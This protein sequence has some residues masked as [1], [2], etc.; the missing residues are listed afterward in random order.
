MTSSDVKD[1]FIGRQVQSGYTLKQRLGEGGMGIVYRA[2]SEFGHEIAIKILHSGTPDGDARFLSEAKSMASI[3]HPNVIELLGVGELEGRTFMAMEFLHGESLADHLRT[4][5][6]LTTTEAL[7]ILLQICAGV[8]AA[9]GASRSEAR[10]RFCLHQWH[11]QG[12]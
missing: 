8:Q 9:H 6:A 12:A 5:P 3:R 1:P 7:P 2:T 10:Q 4:R 11:N